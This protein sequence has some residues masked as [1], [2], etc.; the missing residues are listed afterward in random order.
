MSG[1]SKWSTIKHK[2]GVEDAK[3]GKIFSKIIKEITV[4]A[5]M[6]GGDLAANAGLR[7]VIAKAK[8]ANMPKDNIDKA[9]KKGV[10]DQS[11]ANFEEITYEGYA[12][13]GVGIIIQVLTDNRNRSFADVKSILTKSG[14]SLAAAGAVSYQFKRI[15]T[16]VFSK[17]ETDFDALFEKALDLGA[18]DV[19]EIEDGEM[20]RVTTDPKDFSQVTEGLT[21]AG[22]EPVGAEVAMV[23]DAMVDLPEDKKEK[24]YKIID[25]LEDNDDVQGVFS[26]LQD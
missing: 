8:A 19:E 10:G 25:R 12:P 26:N 1:H 11:G 9:I 23:S 2:K 4:S 20:I 22:F 17:E 5:R 21:E 13:G 14:G 6:G 16:I 7:S 3:R 18:E 15:G 24:V